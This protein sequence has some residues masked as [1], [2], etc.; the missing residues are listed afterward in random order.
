V[1]F[2]KD[3]M[4]LK[5]VFLRVSLDFPLP[6]I[7]NTTALCLFTVPHRY[8]T[9]LTRPHII[10]SSEIKLG[11]L[12]LMQHLCSYRVKKVYTQNFWG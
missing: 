7:L 6:V 3:E 5:Q 9:A 1:R 10:I 11:A 8:I 2:I 12:S 4:A